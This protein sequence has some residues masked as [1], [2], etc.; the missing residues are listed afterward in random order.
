MSSTQKDL[1]VA[2]RKAGMSYRD[3]AEK[4]HTTSDY[5]RTICSR[6]NRAQRQKM[7]DADMGLCLYCGHLVVNTP[8]AKPKHFCSDKCRYDYHNWEK[9]HSGHIRTCETCGNEFVAF[10]NPKKRFCSHDCYC[11]FARKKEESHG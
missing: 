10:G 5:C 8:G 9:K 6:A 2:Y 7:Q 3:I 1:I 11:A 4:T